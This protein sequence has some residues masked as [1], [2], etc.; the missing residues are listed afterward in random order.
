MSPPT[1]RNQQGEPRFW[2]KLQQS[3]GERRQ[4]GYTFA[5]N[6]QPNSGTKDGL[7]H[8]R[9]TRSRRRRA[10]DAP[11]IYSLD[12]RGKTNQIR[13]ITEKHLGGKSSV[14]FVAGR[15]TLD[16]TDSEEKTW[17]IMCVHHSRRTPSHAA[18]ERYRGWKLS[19]IKRTKTTELIKPAAVGEYNDNTRATSPA[20]DTKAP[21]NCS[22]PTHICACRT[23][24]HYTE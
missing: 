12:V 13:A 16:C 21:T 8:F 15:Y 23:T 20:L 19:K 18:Y 24:P 7:G 2:K 6:T 4:R 14:L 9:E 3:G 10:W 5:R 1:N 17:P 11:L 22:R